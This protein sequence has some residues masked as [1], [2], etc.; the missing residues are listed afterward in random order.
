MKKGQNGLK[1]QLSLTTKDRQYEGF[2]QHH[3][4]RQNME[5]NIAS[6]VA[7]IGQDTQSA[8]TVTAGGLLLWVQAG[9]PFGP[10][11]SHC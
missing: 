9:G 3:D 8:P 10:I 6:G 11:V 1:Q 4:W 7:Q 2:W 5:L